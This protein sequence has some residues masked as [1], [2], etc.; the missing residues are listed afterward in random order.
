MVYNQ[1]K[2]ISKNNFKVKGYNS[3]K[4][5]FDQVV[6]ANS[7][8]LLAGTTYCNKDGLVWAIKCPTLTKHVWNK[9]YFSSGYPHSDNWVATDGAE[10]KDW[11]IK[12]VDG[13]YACEYKLLPLEA[14]ANYEKKV[15]MEWINARQNGLNRE[16]IDYVLPL[17]QGDANIPTEDSLP[18]YARLKKI[19]AR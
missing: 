1:P 3:Y 14:V 4:T 7:E 11:Y 19:L 9:L 6:A 12:D 18:R 15:P 2:A 5:K 10:D 17:I 16:F 13:R 8:L